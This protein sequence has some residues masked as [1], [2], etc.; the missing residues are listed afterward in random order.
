[1]KLTTYGAACRKKQSVNYG[2]RAAPEYPPFVRA[3]YHRGR[4][5]AAFGILRTPSLGLH[6]PAWAPF[7]SPM[8]FKELRVELQR[9]R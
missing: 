5:A 4:P 7:P 6:R 3:D 1:M 8:P 9:T 2:A